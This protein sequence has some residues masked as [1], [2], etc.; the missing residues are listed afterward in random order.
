MREFIGRVWGSIL[1][2]IPWLIVAALAIAGLYFY[3]WVAT[4][5]II[6]LFFAFVGILFLGNLGWYFTTVKQGTM[7]FLDTGESLRSIFPNVGGFK[8][9]EVEDIDQR[10]WL[11]PE[12]DSRKQ[13]DSLFNKSLFGTRWFQKWLWRSFGLRFMSFFWPHVHIHLFN[14]RSRKRITSRD[15]VGTDAP[16]KQLV[17]ESGDPI[18]D[19]LLFLV[20]RPVYIEGIELPGDNA[21]INL[22]FL[23][24]FRVVIPSLPV[25]YYQGDF[26]APLDSAIQAA[27][28]DFF[29]T[30]RVA[31]EKGST[32]FAKDTYDPAESA[33][34]DPTPLTYSHWLKLS[35]ASSS[36]LINHLRPLNAS[37]S[38]LADLEAKMGRDSEIVTYL[39]SLIPAQPQD[40][41]GAA[42]RDIPSGIIPRFGFALISF[43]LVEWEEHPDTANLSKAIRLKETRRNEADALREEAYGIRDAAKAKAEGES[44]RFDQTIYAM[45]KHDVDPNV[46]AGVMETQL[47]M[48]SVSKSQLTTYMEGSSRATPGVMVPAS[49]PAPRPSVAPAPATPADTTPEGS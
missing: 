49:T 12:P 5:I 21:K 4:P 22:L 37:A 13:R 47:R 38:Y 48:E 28:V 43:R 16:V 10:R 44:S 7:K 34:Y 29:S 8:L 17:Q 42:A 40:I 35:K 2:M 26:F 41:T 15:K 36:P 23:P 33:Q 20:P 9:S 18:V 31:V 24:V 3:P 32:V 39:R 45:R 14:I 11:V 25:Y 46:A 30:H 19:N 27:I 1:D 6:A